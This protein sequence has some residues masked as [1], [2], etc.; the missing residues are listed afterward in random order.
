MRRRGGR[1]GCLGAVLLSLVSGFFGFMAWDRETSLTAA[2]P[3]EVVR[4][5]NGGTRKEQ[6]RQTTIDYRYVVD[7]RTYDGRYTKRGPNTGL[8]RFQSGKPAKV[9]YNP[10][11]PQVSEPFEPTYTCPN[12]RL[13]KFL[14]GKGQR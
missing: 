13:P 1:I 7:G 4:V 10:A 12:S 2:A 14:R 3:A 11:R 5:Y 8:D 9:C 6:N